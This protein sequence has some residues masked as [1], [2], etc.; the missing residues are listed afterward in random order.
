LAR[1]IQGDDLHSIV[2]NIREHFEWTC[3]VEDL[4]RRRATDDDLAHESIVFPCGNLRFLL[5]K[6]LQKKGG[7]V[8]DRVPV[9]IP[10]FTPNATVVALFQAS[11]SVRRK[12]ISIQSLR[13]DQSGG[14]I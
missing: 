13:A 5:P 9:N 6:Y 3:H 10:S 8:D 7:I 12:I 14:Q 2:R 4:D 11:A 1:P